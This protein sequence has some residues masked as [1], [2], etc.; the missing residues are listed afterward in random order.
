M[1]CISPVRRFAENPPPPP[2]YRCELAHVA[3]DEEG[4]LAV[5][6]AAVAEF[7]TD[8]D[9]LKI[10]TRTQRA[11]EPEGWRGADDRAT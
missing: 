11:L 2:R 1:R 6:N 5:V 7:P 9:L 10:A 3:A 4:A 8:Y